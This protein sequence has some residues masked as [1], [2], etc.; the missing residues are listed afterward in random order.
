MSD[1]S[2]DEQISST[3]QEI[4]LFSGSRYTCM[5]HLWFLVSL[6]ISMV[7]AK[8]ILNF[9]ERIDRKAMYD[10]SAIVFLS[11]TAILM[12]KY[13]DGLPFRL[14]T[15]PAIIVLLIIGNKYKDYVNKFVDG[16]SKWKFYI[17]L[18]C[19]VALSV[20]N[21]TVNMSLAV[22]NNY[23]LYLLTALSGISVIIYIS[24]RVRFKSLSYIGRNTLIL[25]A[26]HGVWIEVYKMSLAK[27]DISLHDMYGLYCYVGTILVLIF[28]F[29]SLLSLRRIYLCYDSALRNFFNIEK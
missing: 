22:Y 4:Y 11:L 25:F 26:I 17:L 18:F 1:E 12:D 13:S 8:F 7:V 21:K 15:V 19:F 9:R 27:I 5:D 24:K 29:F 6:T 16:L 14:Q 20:L 28:S 2:L 23:L 10:I 3:L